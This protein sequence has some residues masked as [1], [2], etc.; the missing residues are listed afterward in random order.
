MESQKHR[1]VESI[2]SEDGQETE[3]LVELSSARS[4]V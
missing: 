2:Q 3:P 1:S 4:L